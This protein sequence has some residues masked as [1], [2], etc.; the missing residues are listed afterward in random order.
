[1]GQAAHENAD[2]VIV[3]D[4]NP[5]NESPAAIRR[6]VLGGAPERRRD[7]RPPRR[8]P[9]RGLCAEGGRHP[10]HRR[11][12]PRDGPDRRRQ[13]AAVLR[14]GRGAGGAEERRRRPR[15]TFL[16]TTEAFVAASGGRLEGSRASCDLRR[17]DRQPHRR[18]GRGLRRDQGRTIRRPR[19]RRTG[20]ESRRG[21]GGRAG[22]ARAARRQ[23]RCSSCP[24][25]RLR[26][27]SGS[28][29]RRARGCAARSS[30]SP[31]R[32]ARPAPR[33]CCASR[34]PRS[35]R[36]MRRSAPSTIIGA[37]R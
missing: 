2:R 11:Q 29:P 12:G 18:A 16:W 3:T 8:D 31:V 19:F 23:V 34:S 10:A 35:A 14:S 37:C 32:S 21:A 25:I 22:G 4:D 28:A 13:G 33:R 5:R 15:M 24:T 36:R 6:A 17:V 1:M 20:V 9:H 26:R 7:R 27:W 30:R